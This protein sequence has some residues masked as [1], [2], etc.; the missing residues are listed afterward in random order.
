MEKFIRRVD[1]LGRLVIPRAYREI[2]GIKDGTT[3]AIL[4]DGDTLMIKIEK[5]ICDICGK[6]TDA[7]V[8]VKDK[9][10]CPECKA[11]FDEYYEKQDIKGLF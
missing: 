1:P 2:L 10:I 7:A 4:L 5:T 11:V 6:E 8:Q 3:M 9:S